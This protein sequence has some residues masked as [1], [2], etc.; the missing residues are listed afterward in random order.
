MAI[1]VDVLLHGI[2]VL[3]CCFLLFAS[4]MAKRCPFMALVLPQVL[5]DGRVIMSRISIVFG[6]L[7]V[8]G[9]LVLCS[10]AMLND[11]PSMQC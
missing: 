8:L 5:I 1:L 3:S 4:S 2:F 6:P 10:D 7:R 9:V 11:C